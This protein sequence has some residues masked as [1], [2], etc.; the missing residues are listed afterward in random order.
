MLKQTIL[1]LHRFWQNVSAALKFSA[2]YISGIRKNL[3]KCKWIVCQWVSLMSWKPHVIIYD[4]IKIH[5][6]PFTSLQL[7]SES[8]LWRAILQV[9]LKNHKP[10]LKFED[11]HV[12]RTA[13]K[14]ENFVGY[15]HK[16][17]EKL[18]LDLQVQSTEKQTYRLFIS[19]SSSVFR[20]V[21]PISMELFHNGFDLWNL[22]L[23]TPCCKATTL[24]YL[25]AFA[26]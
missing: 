2:K 25:N 22:E 10:D 1:L 12:G 21:Y 17:F 24:E 19:L 4:S 13:K 14:C 5:F 20:F 23:F 18:N 11:Q 26:A 3:P 6:C 15:V 8:L 16:S 9:I 7:P